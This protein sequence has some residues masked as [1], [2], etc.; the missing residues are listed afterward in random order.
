LSLATWILPLARAF[1]HARIE[2]LQHLA[3]VN[4]PVVFAAN[5]QSHMDVPVILAALPG[6]WRARIAPAMAKEFFKAHFFPAGYTWRQRLTNSLNYYLAAFYFNAF[7]L[8]QR[9]AG[10]RQTLQYIGDLVGA[11]WSVLLFPEGERRATGDI[12]RFRGGIGMIASRLEVPVIP[13]RLD[14]LDR[15]L[16]PKWKMARPGRVRVAF[17]EPLH[18]RGDDY[19]MLARRVEERVRAL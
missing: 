14:G 16:H 12:M 1:A 11:G 18:L 10:A 4:G 7:P 17:G 6:S 9:E 8:P 5:H 15:V 3:Q 2:G 13:V 19:E